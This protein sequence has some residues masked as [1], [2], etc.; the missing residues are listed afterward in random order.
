MHNRFITSA[1][2]LAA[3]LG[4]RMQ[5]LT[6]DR[7]KPLI[8]VAGKAL[9]DHMIAALEAEG[10][11]QFAINAHY[12]PEQIEAHISGLVTEKPYI[13]FALS[14]EPKRLLDTGGGAKKAMRLISGDPVLVANTDAFWPTG[15]DTPLQRLAAQ[16]SESPGLTLLCVLP[17]HATGFRRSHDFCLAPDK[18]ITLDR[19]APIIYT[20]VMLV[21]RQMLSDYPAE[22]FSTN[23][24]MTIAREEGTLRGVLLNAPWHHVGDPDG[25][26]EAEAALS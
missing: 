9:I 1:V 11:S 26:K 23:D 17:M 21:P 18:T 4:T 7:P 16:Y 20:G 14:K 22:I 12:F 24:L 25:L 2:L 10:V 19:G 15:I 6:A 13:Q 8:E 5:P 3:G